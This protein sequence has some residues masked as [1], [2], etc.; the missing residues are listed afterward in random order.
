MKRF[1][2]NLSDSSVR[3]MA[4]V[5]VILFS[6]LTSQHSLAQ[7]PI[8]PLWSFAEDAT[9]AQWPALPGSAQEANA[10]R[11]NAELLQRL[12][13]GVT[14]TAPSRD[15]SSASAS[16]LIT[17]VSHYINGD[18]VFSGDVFTDT[19]LGPLVMTL[20][21]NSLFAHIESEEASWQLYAIRQFAD[22]DFLGWVYRTNAQEGGQYE[23][24][25]V[26]RKNVLRRDLTPPRHA[27]QP[28]SVASPTDG[29]SFSLGKATAASSTSALSIS[30]AFDRRS[31]IK[32]DTL[33]GTVTVSNNS[34]S[35]M[36]GLSLQVYF[37]LENTNLVSASA[38]CGPTTAGGQA[39]LYC[40]LASIPA[41]SSLDIHYQVGVSAQSKPHVY[42]TA[43]VSDQ[44]DDTYIGVVEDVL[45]DSDLDGVSDIDE[46][47]LGSNPFDG[48]SVSDGPTTID[49]MA[50]YTQGAQQLYSGQAETRINQLFAMA[51][52]VFADSGADIILRPVHHRKVDYSDAASMDQALDAMTYFDDP[53]LGATAFANMATLRAKF[54]ADVVMLFRPLGVEKSICGL[55]NLGGFA[56]QGDFIS[57]SEKDYAYANI[58]IDCPVGTVV[59]HEI[60]HIMGLTHSRREDITGGTFDYSTGYGIDSSFATVMAYPAAFNT[61]NRLGRFSNPDLNCFG[62]ACGVN[63]RS[64]E[65][66][67]AVRSLNAT[68]VQIGSYYDTRVVPLTARVV[69]TLSGGSTDAHISLAA[70]VN[71]GLS[72]V[73]QVAAQKQV[74]VNLRLQIDSRHAGKM[75]QIHV[76]AVLDGTPF[77]LNV[78]GGATLWD[79]SVE[80]LSGFTP[81][82][83]LLP[84]VYLKILNALT[85][86]PE[87]ANHHLQ[88][89]AAYSIDSKSELVFTREPLTL[90][91]TL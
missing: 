47:L 73:S 27:A 33:G 31:V 24:D 46:T 35:V 75:G 77:V 58:A 39:V 50:L 81:E 30:Q 72:L 20:G 29:L 78:D 68:R 55:A 69:A 8:Y 34:A 76:L 82:S 86:G 45:R 79:G 63:Y 51:N 61:D 10:I 67:D 1:M 74:D 6:L 66:A 12:A 49:V 52:Q 40:P 56:T 44:R 42:S 19:W 57:S 22:Q 14:V 85:V 89:F 13:V 38:G 15:G 62:H 26:L 3:A 17:D 65:G 36:N 28:L 70:S 9:T 87:F 25:Y 59:A 21:E 32:G 11:V 2:L 64:N 83:T 4:V 5:C 80:A 90:D 41:N 23:N 48:G 43:I 16:V 60:G 91:F 84:V 7:P 18:V 53:E 71:E 37:L 88:I 54:G